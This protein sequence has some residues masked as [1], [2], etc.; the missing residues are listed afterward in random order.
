MEVDRGQIEHVII[1]LV[2]N[3]SDAMPHGG[4]L[5]IETANVDLDKVYDGHR[6]DKNMRKKTIL[7]A[8]DE[9][10]IGKLLVD[11]LKQE[12]YRFFL[13]SNGKDALDVVKRTSIDVAI[14]D[15]VM[16]VMDGI[17]ALK[18]IKEIDKSIEVLIL[19]AY[20]NFGSLY[21]ILNNGDAFD[22]VLKPVK[23]N[24]I[25]KVIQ[26]ALHKR[27]LGI[28]DKE[29]SENLENR[30]KEL[31][32]GFKEKNFQLRESQIRYK[33][34][35]EKSNDMITVAQHGILKF[36]NSKVMNSLG[37]AREEILN[38]PFIILVHP[39]DQDEVKTRYAK[40]LENGDVSSIFPFRILRKD[41]KAL[42]VETS[43]VR[44]LWEGKPA[45]L[46]IIRDISK[47]KLTEEQLTASLAEKEM[48]LREIHH[49]VKN[50]LQ[51]I[52][53]LLRLRAAK[54]KESEAQEA[55]KDS[56]DRVMAMSL[57]H[58][59]LYQSEDFANVDLCDY[60]TKLETS[61]FQAG[62][63]VGK[64][65][66][67]EKN[68]EPV[69][70]PLNQA[71]PCGLV[72]NELLTNALKHAFPEGASGQIKVSVGPID[73]GEVEIIISDNGVGFPEG[74][75]FRKAESVGLSLIVGI[76]EKQLDGEIKL[77]RKAGAEFRVRFK[78]EEEE[79]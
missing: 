14:L 19:T 65:I 42:S 9:E 8:D 4:K 44:S 73:P 53:S 54:L 23:G 13:V 61:L 16:P 35:V 78:V 55:L 52:S 25:R 48:L 12:D 74:L 72:I 64:R 29:T 6:G 15:I 63:T 58:E 60:I 39:L 47:R 77:N 28:S 24:E 33:E 31:E 69:L 7:I 38:K 1:N 67:L 5:V 79:G 11:I 49:R 40:Q 3:A 75:D 2:V 30:V 70:L 50:N 21:E 26:M 32:R 20:A 41:G 18:Q 57:V 34:I 62:P 56:Q 51:I 59:I 27:E 10:I 66:T 68:F 22:Y 36:V 46:N 43:S 45:T 17:E 37:Y 71:L 76:V